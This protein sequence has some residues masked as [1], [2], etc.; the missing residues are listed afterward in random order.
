MKA[1]P[2]SPKV[3]PD[4]AMESAAAPGTPKICQIVLG[5]TDD[6][7][8]NKNDTTD[9]GAVD[10]NDDTK[11]TYEERKANRET[12]KRAVVD[13]RAAANTEGGSKAGESASDDEGA[14]NAKFW[15]ATHMDDDNFVHVGGSRRLATDGSKLPQAPSVSSNHYVHVCY[16]VLTLTCPPPL[17]TTTTTATAPAAVPKAGDSEGQDNARESSRGGG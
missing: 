16:F 10:D 8:H 5:D 13:A 15:G 4:T 3:V 11:L 9:D 1:K 14:D 2:R 17:P 12:R 6:G 7:D